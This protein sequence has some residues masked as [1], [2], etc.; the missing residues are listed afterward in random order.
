MRHFALEQAARGVRVA[1][2]LAPGSHGQRLSTPAQAAAPPHRHPHRRSASSRLDLARRRRAGLQLRIAADTT[3]LST[4]EDFLAVYGAGKADRGTPV[5]HGPLLPPHAPEDR[6]SSWHRQALRR[7]VLLRRRQ[8]QPLP[9]RSPRPRAAHPSRRTPSPLEVI[10]LVSSQR[11]HFGS[12]ENFDLPCTQDDCAACWQFALRHL[13]PHFGPFEDAM[14]DDQPSSST[15][16]PPPSSTS[17]A[18]SA[19]TSSTTSNRRDARHD[20]PGKRRR[21]HPSATW[22]ARVHAAPARA[23]RRLPHSCRG[24]VPRP[25]AE[26]DL[27]ANEYSHLLSQGAPPTPLPPPDPTP[28]PPPPPST[29]TCPCHRRL[30]GRQVRPP[31]P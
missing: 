8:P 15:P 25:A 4:P 13:L 6:P 14:R 7:Q 11:H 3:W 9:R 27:S 29:P 24:Q 28:A 30:L 12:F 1:L 21:L 5:R 10:A 16:K 20:P 17:A 22:L 26:Q 31:L 19:L 23:D 2:P 18:C